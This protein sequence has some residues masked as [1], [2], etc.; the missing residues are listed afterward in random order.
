MSDFESGAFNRA[1]PPLRSRC[2]Y[3][4]RIS[5]IPSAS[6][7]TKPATRFSRNKNPEIL[8]TGA[9]AG[10]TPG[11]GLPGTEAKKHQVLLGGV[12]WLP[13]NA[14]R[15]K[16]AAGVGRIESPPI[17]LRWPGPRGIAWLELGDRKQRQSHTAASRESRTPSDSLQRPPDRS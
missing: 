3:L 17:Q 9:Q 15:L 2:N 4:R 6:C 12:L 16:R 11:L 1:L 14:P 8:R 13:T 10:I 7:A 5:I